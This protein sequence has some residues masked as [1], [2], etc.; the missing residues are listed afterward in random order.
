MLS[1]EGGMVFMKSTTLTHV[2]IVLLI[3]LA[4][5]VCIVLQKK[6]SEVQPCRE[7]YITLR[8][9]YVDLARSHAQMLEIL[10][11]ASPEFQ[12][13]IPEYRHLGTAALSETLHRRIK[14]LRM[15]AETLEMEQ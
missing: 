11:D 5:A 6:P 15:K 3:V 10:L 1:T 4:S 2:F 9:S 14:E 13:A 7:K 12:K 8:G